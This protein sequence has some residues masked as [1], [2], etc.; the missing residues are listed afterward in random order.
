MAS[1][2]DKPST[3]YGMYGTRV[4]GSK[5]VSTS[6]KRRFLL[7]GTGPW[8]F[9]PLSGT[10]L[11]KQ[12][13]NSNPNWQANL[14]SLA[15][16]VKPHILNYVRENLVQDSASQYVGYTEIGDESKSSVSTPDYK[17]RSAKGEVFNNPFSQSRI[18]LKSAQ[19]DVADKSNKD[20]LGSVQ[21]QRESGS[22]SSNYWIAVTAWEVR[23][24]THS[25]C[26]PRE[27][28]D[29]LDKRLAMFDPGAQSAINSA[30]GNMQQGEVELLVMAAEGR[31]TLQH[32][33][34][35]IVR[36]VSLVSAIRRRD[37]SRLCP[38]TY[39]AWR[40]G[41]FDG[42]GGTKKFFE[43]AW[44]EARYAWLP[45]VMDAV[46]LANIVTGKVVER[47]TFRSK[48]DDHKILD[49]DFPVVTSVGSM[50]FTGSVTLIASARAG[51]L[52]QKAIDSPLAHQFGIFNIATMAKEVI[53]FSF[54]LEWFINLSGLLYRLNPNPM[55][56]PLAAWCT[57]KNE[58]SIAGTLQWT[59]INAQPLEIPI[60]GS[61]ERKVR[62]PV[63]EPSLITID[64]N[65]GIARFVDG[66]I[67]SL[68]KLR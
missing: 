54:V 30:F 21:I 12:L 62:V 38:K 24:T 40:K 35:T 27:F 2:N 11:Y 51:V 42:A 16:Q 46:G 60:V 63:A 64:A 18:R 19:L 50:K 20:Y 53:P 49:L 25:L 41:S 9:G 34:S 48:R 4:R 43:D 1:S 47:Q 36:F 37:I 32:L 55:L 61:L 31:K 14:N 56:K 45:L 7:P 29:E 58:S 5:V 3:Q 39:K 67:L 65:I 22:D 66:A 17:R 57:T 52:T 26:I 10:D 33:L 44:M 8:T 13:A 6:P 15:M 68:R 23:E 59:P 28:L